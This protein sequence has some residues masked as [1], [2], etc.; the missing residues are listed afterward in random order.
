MAAAAGFLAI[1]RWVAARGGNP[2]VNVAVLARPAVCW[3]LLTLLAAIGTYYALLFTLAQ[4]LQQGLGH[5]PLVSGLTLLPWVAGFGLA[6]QLVRRLPARTTP[7]AP[8]AG[9]LLLTAAY[10][11]IST[12]LFTGHHGEQVLA[13][14]FGL[15]GLGLGIQFNAL[16]AH[17]TTVVP[18]SYAP[19]ISGVSTT[20]IQ[21]G[22][23]VAV[24][25]FGTLYFSASTHPGAGHPTHGFA[26]TTA[27]LTTVA[28]LA[29]LAA[30]RATRS[31]AADAVHR[32]ARPITA[33]TRL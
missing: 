20:T 5:S 17:L 28:L 6:G 14:V 15:G 30:H 16:I 3:A 10:A 13:V 19:D 12:A 26:L 25:A 27:A 18:A 31:S 24:A 8:L 21:I 29:S 33:G 32:Q 23:A 9:W 2:L 7:T 4:Y 1:E 11:A 22:A